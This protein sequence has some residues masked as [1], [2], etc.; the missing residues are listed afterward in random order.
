MRP[1]RLILSAFG[2]YAGETR[3]DFSVLGEDGVFLIA[4]DTGAGKTTIFDAISFALYGEGS[5]GKERR[6]SRSFRS[7]YAAPGTQTFVELTFGHRGGTYRIRRNPEYERPKRTGAGMTV[8]PADAQLTDLD[9]GEVTE[10]LREVDTRIY[11]LLGLTQDQ[12]SR[13]VMIAQGDFMKILN[14]TS[15]ERKALF[16]KL[17]DTSLYADLQRKLQE[18]NTA[19]GKEREELDRCVVIAGGRVDPEADDPEREQIFM[20]R[21]DAK[22]ADLLAGCLERL[23]GRERE[24]RDVARREKESAGERVAR[25]IAEMERGKAINADLDTLLEAESEL[26]ALLAG[27]AQADEK[28]LRLGRARKAQTLAADDALLTR[29]AEEIRMLEM[30]TE[31]TA[32]EVASVE[33][34]L[35]GAEAQRSEAES[36]AAGTDRLLETARLLSGCVP[37]LRELCLEKKNAEK[38]R[39]RIRTLLEES[40]KADALCT[41]AKDGYYRSQAGL[42]ALGLT[43]G[44][45]CPVCGSE[46]H[47]APAAL[48]AE[49]VTREKM[50]EA[51]K[52]RR[53]AEAALH[54]ADA[55]LA[56]AEASVR[57]GR[58]R[59]REAGVSEAETETHL[60]ETAA[61]LRERAER[62]RKAFEICRKACEDLRTRLEAER[63]AANRGEERL[64][65]LRESAKELD[66]RFR[67]KLDAS[68]FADEREYRDAVLAEEEAAALEREIRS[69]EESKRSL[70]DRIAALRERVAGKERVDLERLEK[71]REKEKTEQDEAGRREAS[72]LRRLTLHEDALREI[73]EARKKRKR[74]EEYWAVVR[75]LYNCCAGITGG[76]FRAKITF[77]AYVQQYWFR[78]IVSAANRRLTVLTDGMFTLRCKQE[79]RDRVRQSGLDLDVFDRSTGLWRDVSTLSGGESFLASL[80]LALGLSDVVQGQSGAIRMEAMFIDE[81]FGTLDDNALRNSLRVLS[82]LADGK[83][84]IGII[85]HVH[86]LEERIEKQIVVTK[87]IRGSKITTVS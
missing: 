44:E 82:D 42:L 7:D 48:P 78:Q 2:P 26:S 73:T 11:E 69:R 47:P 6:K 35:P 13:T 45:P 41:V 80:A 79:A 72:Y 62:Y 51:E 59:L 23:T 68:G 86:D 58:E 33:E 15:D 49:A 81:G 63:T 84:L 57:T 52:L 70:S 36:R 38:Q 31:K 83:R 20:Y 21:T 54:E 28:A 76:N 30:E 46:S 61:E 24:A 34:A 9:S 87:T 8:Q 32:A 50:E 77:E 17:F 12:F 29:T 37:V 40:A 4:G 3:I 75:D 39:E 18:M 55:K 16:Q 66:R 27:Q 22:Y 5:G 25:L 10:G 53:E 74:R 14:A 71:E 56:A 19:C 1:I 43:P 67:E 64:S 65:S 85:S 60:M